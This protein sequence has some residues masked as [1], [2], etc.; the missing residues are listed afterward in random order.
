[1]IGVSLS[2]NGKMFYVRH[3]FDVEIYYIFSRTQ[4]DFS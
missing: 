3:H 1:M 4:L 2:Q